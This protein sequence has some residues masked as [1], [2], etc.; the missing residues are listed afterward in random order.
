MHH[1]AILS[2]FL[3]G[4]SIKLVIVCQ[5]LFLAPGFESLDFYFAIENLVLWA[6]GS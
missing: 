3:E 5:A 6:S 4:D 2:I 1:F